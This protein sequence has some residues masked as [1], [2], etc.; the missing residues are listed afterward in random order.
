MLE[1]CEKSR[2]GLLQLLMRLMDF[3]LGSASSE[4]DFLSSSSSLPGTNLGGEKVCYLARDIKYQDSHLL[5]PLLALALEREGRSRLRSVPSPLANILIPAMP[6]C[7]CP[8][9]Q[10]WCC[11]APQK[12]RHGGICCQ[13]RVEP[14]PAP[15]SEKPF[16]TG[17]GLIPA[18]LTSQRPWRSSS[19]AY[20]IWAHRS[21]AGR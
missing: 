3:G 15:G 21:P 20:G 12:T 7:P 1:S 13:F 17:L 19:L 2:K 6:L 11:L 18:G 5:V 8:S 16:W 14:L 9:R 10:L 4:R